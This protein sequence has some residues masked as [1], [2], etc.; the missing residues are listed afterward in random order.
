MSTAGPARSL[1]TGRGQQRALESET[2][3]AWALRR[4]LLVFLPVL[5]A[6]A[7]LGFRLIDRIV[8]SDF[9]E[10]ATSI[11][12]DSFYY[13]IPA[14]RFHEAGFFTFDGVSR[15]Y[16]FQPAYEC[17]LTALAYFFSDQQAFIRAAMALNVLLHTATAVLIAAAVSR[18]MSAHTP[19]A[20]TMQQLIAGLSGVLYCT[21]GTIFLSAITCKE[22]ALSALLLVTA[23]V[24]LPLT[25][26][27]QGR[28]RTTVRAFGLGGIV[29]LLV[30]CRIL[31]STLVLAAVLSLWILLRTRA[32]K[33]FAIGVC[34]PFVLW[35]AAA[36]VMFGHILPTSIWIKAATSSGHGLASLEALE[37]GLRYTYQALRFAVGAH[38]EFALP[39]YD[40]PQAWLDGFY[41]RIP[42]A[43]MA[44]AIFA[45]FASM[46]TP[47]RDL[48][49][50][51]G[52]SS[53]VVLCLGGVFLAYPI[54]GALVASHR[55]RELYY[56]TWYVYELPVLLWMAMG[57][58]GSMII[59]SMERLRLSGRSMGQR[60]AFA[61]ALVVVTAV[62]TPGS[63]R[64]LTYLW[65]LPPYDRFNPVSTDWQH[66]MVRSGLWFRDN[67]P[68]RPEERVACSNCGALALVLPNRLVTIDGLASDETANFR[69]ENPG[70]S[71][72]PFVVS[73]GARY[74]I[75][76][77][78]LDTSH[79]AT[80]L[81]R[82]PFDHGFYLVARLRHEPAAT[83]HR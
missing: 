39:Q 46:F 13:L 41:T 54:Q 29:A 83:A 73:R 32:R 77:E 38:T 27:E 45:F 69:L 24:C 6:A 66:T 17:V 74:W 51:H 34:L 68:L 55:G 28:Y 8:H 62:F 72:I 50:H 80:V 35:G 82:E 5:A 1:E 18:G 64:G 3:A 2:W 81:H 22:N 49:T 21:T 12:D 48:K 33:A 19:A 47:L 53:A 65:R 70:Q 75:D 61:A 58:G 36:L 37:A 43:V 10:L 71:P 4:R 42:T 76:V 59:R 60:Y 14:F 31:P 16:G 57:V 20:R 26:E 40:A 79:I 30:L 9:L 15:T 78:G 67:V 23:L 63:A 7:F 44:C 56:Y 25:V 52:L 11:Q